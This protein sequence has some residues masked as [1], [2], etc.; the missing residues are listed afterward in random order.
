MFTLLIMSENN[1][2][3][4]KDQAPAQSPHASP[5]RDSGHPDHPFADLIDTRQLRREWHEALRI[6]HKAHYYAAKR[7]QTYRLTLGIPTIMLSAIAG[8]TLFSTFEQSDNST[9]RIVTGV[10][11]LLVSVLSSLQTFLNFGERSERHKVAATKYGALRRKVELFLLAPD[12]AGEKNF[13]Q[14]VIEEWNLIDKEAPKIPNA[15][16]AAQA[17]KG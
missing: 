10:T 4:V 14:T 13:W 12:P 15:I 2:T 16:Y 6:V 7:Y 8:T 9:L 11:V 3:C 1:H 17:G 5:D